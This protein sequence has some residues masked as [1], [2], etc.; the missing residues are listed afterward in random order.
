VNC[1]FRK[2]VRFSLLSGRIKLTKFSENLKV[3]QG[4]CKVLAFSEFSF[5]FNILFELCEA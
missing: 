3:G 1:W 4:E 5:F 2:N